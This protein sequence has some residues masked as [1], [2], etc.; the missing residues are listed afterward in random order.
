MKHK[1]VSALA[2]GCLTLG[3]ASN[4]WCENGEISSTSAHESLSIGQAGD[5]KVS[6]P[7]VVEVD[8]Q[9][10]SRLS[11]E[12]RALVRQTLDTIRKE[13]SYWVKFRA[14]L[15][16]TSF[17]D[18]GSRIIELGSLFKKP[19]GSELKELA[20]DENGNQRSITQ[21][22]M[23]QI[24]NE[25]LFVVPSK[26]Y[27]G[28]NHVW[29][30]SLLI[31]KGAENIKVSYQEDMATALGQILVQIPARFHQDSVF[32]VGQGWSHFYYGLRGILSA[33][34]GMVEVKDKYSQVDINRLVQE[35]KK[36]YVKSGLEQHNQEQSD[37]SETDFDLRLYDQELTDQMAPFLDAVMR[38]FEAYWQENAYQFRM[39]LKD[40][41]LS[42]GIEEEKMENELNKQLEQLKS[43][44]YHEMLMA[45]E[46]LEEESPGY[47][48][49]VVNRNNAIKTAEMIETRLAT[50]VKAQEE[51][52]A[53]ELQLKYPVLSKIDR[54][55]QKRLEEKSSAFYRE[56]RW[57][58][59]SLIPAVLDS[60]GLKQEAYQYTKMID[61]QKNL[62]KN[63]I[64][65]LE[66]EK[67]PA[68]DFEI[69]RKIWSSQNW[70]VVPHTDANG[71]VYHYSLETY[72]K[73][74]VST[75][76]NLWRLRQVGEET[77]AN[78]KNGLY[79]MVVTNLWNGPVG[80]KSLFKKDP[81][82]AY[83]KVD[84]DTGEIVD[85]TSDLTGTYTSRL[86]QVWQDARDARDRFESAPDTG[87]LGKRYT[88][89]LNRLWHFAIKGV[90]RT[91]MV[92]I[93][94]PVATV[95]NAVVSTCAVATAPV[96]APLSSM[97]KLGFSATIYDVSAPHR[98][99]NVDKPNHV[100]FP[101]A[102]YAVSDVA[103]QGV[104][105]MAGAAMAAGIVHPLT[106][107]TVGAY[108]MVRKWARTA[109]DKAMG[110]IFLKHGRQPA[111]NS[112]LAWRIAGPGL[113]ANYFYQIHSEIALL[114]LQARLE[115]MELEMFAH[116]TKEEINKPLTE[117]QKFFQDVVGFSASA[118]LNKNEETYK[119]M[120]KLNQEQLD[121]LQKDLA[122]R[123]NLLS[124]ISS[125]PVDRYLIKQSAE[126]LE[127]T[128]ADA[129]M[130]VEAFYQEKLISALDQEQLE[131][132][133][134]SYDL[135]VGDYSGLARKLVV[136]ALSPDF[137]E[138]LEVTDETLVIEVKDDNLSVGLDELLHPAA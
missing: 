70:Q 87:F 21:D 101:M 7:V 35:K 9:Y 126:E 20:M 69:Q 59:L 134:K 61:F 74:K 4:A 17:K 75:D 26:K 46:D 36:E 95:C 38:R 77:R 5:V 62:E 39:D 137:L 6:Y 71:K 88:R 68:R 138:P 51:V 99:G 130:I 44:K 15:P 78:F 125:L 49:L 1:L 102:S 80:I 13:L 45:D 11:K 109:Y 63:I 43:E 129:A 97:F 65:E 93:G 123:R 136:E 24:R 60:K 82:Y 54:W 76:Q 64:E 124:K 34:V 73:L 83:K 32:S 30:L 86:N 122:V 56:V 55:F 10:L 52:F 119:N 106:A 29:K 131:M 98:N 84:Q 113:S 47:A 22:Q 33:L 18:D 50:M 135:K 19:D 89:W 104:A 116:A 91:L 107:G 92:A 118:S 31:Q 108:A 79:A 127:Q 2:W 111:N 58:M 66:Q 53:Q 14:Q 37:A 100:W 96:W 105:Q 48:Q 41:L 28:Q 72:S 42:R 112:F 25:G 120:Q 40:N 81:Y 128:L 115:K 114:A 23:E 3:A 12:R 16:D 121:D 103:V 132:I 85:D 90:S 8:E 94:Q 117:Y 133:W 27:P 67:I 57:D 110:K